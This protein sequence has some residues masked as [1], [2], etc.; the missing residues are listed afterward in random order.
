MPYLLARRLSRILGIPLCC[1]LHTTREM[2]PQKGLDLAGRLQNTKDAYACRS[3]T[4]LSGARVLLVDD[5]I[6]T[7][8]TVSACALA[9]LQGGAVSVFAV[10]V[11]AKEE[12]PPEK[13]VPKQQQPQE[14][15]SK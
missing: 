4:D 3:G 11:A 6:T 12:L 5:I 15:Q 1:P 14:K 8:S 2:K 9:L 10:S 7:G 13:R